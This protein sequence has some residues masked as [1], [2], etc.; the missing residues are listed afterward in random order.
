M[1]SGTSKATPKRSGRIWNRVFEKST[2]LQWLRPSINEWKATKKYR[3]VLIAA[4]IWSLIGIW[5][6]DSIIE[7]VLQW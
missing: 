3:D 7:R 4:A 2:L 5:I 6:W 1:T